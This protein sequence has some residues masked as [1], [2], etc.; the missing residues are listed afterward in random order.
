MPT[1][2]R[3]VATIG[4][5][6]ETSEAIRALVDAGASVFRLN[7]SHNTLGWHEEVIA[8][9]RAAAPT[10]P[11]LMDIPGRKIR[12]AN[13]DRPRDFVTGDILHFA[14]AA[15]VSEHAV[16]VNSDRLAHLCSVGQPLLADDGSLRFTVLSVDGEVVTARAEWGG[17]L[18]S[19]KGLN[20]PG[21]DLGP[22]SLTNQD[23]AMLDFAGRLGVDYVGISFVESAEHVHLVRA[24]MPADSSP[25]IVSKIESAKGF[26]HMEEVVSVSDAVMVDRGDLSVETDLEGVAIRQ[27]TIIDMARR[28][29][30]PVIVATEMLHSMITATAPTKAEVSDITN[31]VLD[32]CAATMLSGE[33]AVGVDP[34]AAVGLMSRVIAAAERARDG[35]SA[36]ESRVDG[37][38]GAISRAIAGLVREL[39]IDKVVAVTRSGY[40]ARVLSGANLRIPIIAVSDRAGAARAFGL[41]PGVTGVQFSGT[42]SRS[43]VSHV[44]AVLESLWREGFITAS[45]QVLVSALAY[46]TSGKRMNHLETH[47]IGDLAR[48]LGWSSRR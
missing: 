9:I 15:S 11:I 42:F 10:H 18:R 41:F 24:A 47:H 14:P 4:P 12:T 3:I 44:P 45:E 19:R 13:L 39:R 30:T 43:D 36:P 5:A 23:R 31:A 25:R 46:P 37:P 6:S 28:T 17:T 26:V 2:T 38:A 1:R 33:T 34:A 20:L 35:E 27:K 8:R 21:A 40:A 16:P 29:A 22:A 32:G 48:A 7:G